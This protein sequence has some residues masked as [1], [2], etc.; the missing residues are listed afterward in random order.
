MTASALCRFGDLDRVDHRVAQVGARLPSW[1]RVLLTTVELW[2]SRRLARAGM[3]GRTAPSQR[4]AHRWDSRR[5]AVTAAAAVGAA[6]AATLAGLQF[7]GAFA[8]D[9]AQSPAAA[10]PAATA[11]S[12][13]VAAANGTA[14]STATSASAPAATARASA[15]APAV[16]A[17]LAKAESEAATWIAGEVSDGAT[18]GCDPAGCP[19]LLARGVAASRLVTL[20][21]DLAGVRKATVIAVPAATS[22]PG[23]DQDAPG[24]VAAFGTGSA[25]VEV[26]A[27]SAG[28]AAGYQSA[29]RS[30]LSA[31]TSAGTQLLGNPRL[32][33]APGDAA[34]L[35]AGKVDARVLAT[36]ATLSTQYK[37]RVAA[38]TDAAPGALPL[39]RGVVFTGIVTAGNGAVSFQQAL[40]LVG[41]QHG[42]YRPAHAAVAT[43]ASGK[44]ALTLRFTSPSPLGLLTPVLTAAVQRGGDAGDG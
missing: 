29:W 6:T 25:R 30:D 9:G 38:F 41:Q 31:R 14:A 42:D 27:V 28:G 5:P 16:V 10:G 15:S 20:G 19:A 32:R 21:P 12:T 4:L 1:G 26:R 34:L 23:V 7:S 13:G 11:T 8:A 33:F 18:I 3:T 40:A 37:L 24:L 36:L 43:Q 44:P 2:A 17:P 22:A 39:F 35:R